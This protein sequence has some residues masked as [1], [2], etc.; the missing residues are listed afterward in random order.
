MPKSHL[1]YI[2]QKGS[3]QI[4]CSRAIFSNEEIA[5]IEKYGHWFEALI[6]GTLT[7]ISQEQKDFINIFQHNERPITPEQIAW[8]KYIKRLELEQKNPKNS[9]STIPPMLKIPSSPA[10]IGKP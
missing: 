8:F 7:P 4:N 3:F 6:N 10:Q 1:T 5:L 9:T 2:H